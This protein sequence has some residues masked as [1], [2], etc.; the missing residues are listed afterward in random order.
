MDFVTGSTPKLKKS[1]VVFS[2]AT[3]LQAEGCSC[4]HGVKNTECRWCGPSIF[5]PL[6]L[7]STEF[8][9]RVLGNEPAVREQCNGPAVSRIY[10]SKPPQAALGSVRSALARVGT[11]KAPQT[12]LHPPSGC[13]EK[14]EPLRICSVLDELRS[15]PALKRARG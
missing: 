5:S 11:P 2:Q 8:C 3:F 7:A 14:P 4:C 13:G 9:G 1:L 10:E 6:T 15:F 12:S